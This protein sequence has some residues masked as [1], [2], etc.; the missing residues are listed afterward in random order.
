MRHAWWRWVRAW[1]RIWRVWLSPLAVSL[2]AAAPQTQRP[3]QIYFVGYGI[4]FA[5]IMLVVSF[6]T[7]DVSYRIRLQQRIGVTGML[8]TVLLG[9]FLAVWQAI[10]I[11]LVA[12]VA[13]YVVLIQR[14]ATLTNRQASEDNESEE[15]HD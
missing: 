13:G 6:F 1:G 4:A 14:S 15:K 12:T 9:F 10:F 3:L 5:I 7:D 11:A 2:L 8:V